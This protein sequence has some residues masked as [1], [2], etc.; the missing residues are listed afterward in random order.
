[1]KIEMKR[2]FTALSI[3]LTLTS[4]YEDYVMDYDYTAAYVAYQYDLR[5]FVCGEDVQ[6]SFTTA[7]GGTIS[8]TRDRAVDVSISNALLT[9]DLSVYDPSG[10]SRSFTAM[11]GLKGL[12]PIGLLSQE[13]VSD[14][15][16][17]SGITY[18]K[19]LP[20]SY[21]TTSGPVS[22]KKGYHTGNLY[23]YPTKAM[24]MDE[25]VLKPYYALGF[26]VNSV[27]ADSLIRDKSFQIMAV[28]VENRFYGNWNHGGRRLVVKNSDGSHVIDDRYSLVL[29]Q[30]EKDIYVLTTEGFNT[31]LT[32]KIANQQ[33]RLRLT[34]LEN[35]KIKIEDVTGTYQIEETPGRPS[36]HN[37][38]KLIQDREIYLNYKYSNKN[39]TTSYVTDTLRFRNRIRDGINEWQDENTK[40]YK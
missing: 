8:N 33:G 3:L 6:V 32:D 30:A 16:K 5:T 31:V 39:G 1:M 15:I 7:L 22:I 19:P 2:I 40:H 34:F 13:Y 20:K 36:Y 11:D 37:G 24:Y 4:C 18:L 26:V 21:Y 29:P 17:A 27:D 23:I 38:A 28:K 35:N 12:A 14:Q 25:K 9:T 10:N